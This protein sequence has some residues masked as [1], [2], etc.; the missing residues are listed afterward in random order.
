MRGSIQSTLGGY[1]MADCVGISITRH[2]N[3]TGK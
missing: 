1:M 2:G 3:K